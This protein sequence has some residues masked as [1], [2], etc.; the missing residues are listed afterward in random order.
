MPFA[1]QESDP[2]DGIWP[3]EAMIRPPIEV[4]GEDGSARPPDEVAAEATPSPATSATG[5][6][7][8]L[9]EGVAAEG[10]QDIAAAAGAFTAKVSWEPCGPGDVVL[11]WMNS[12]FTDDS[13]VFVSVAAIDPQAS[14]RE[15]P[16]AARVMVAHVR[17]Q[18]GRLLIDIQVHGEQPV[19]PRIDILVINP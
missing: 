16:A 8:W 10:L 1:P 2:P 7:L 13:R 3:D 4:L 6:V 9:Q 5:S 17:P 14:S 12:A 19:R 11:G 15:Q 18:N